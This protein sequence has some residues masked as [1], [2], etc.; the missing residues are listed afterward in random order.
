MSYGEGYCLS[1]MINIPVFNTGG[2]GQR[3]KINIM[4][5]SKKMPLQSGIFSFFSKTQCFSFPGLSKPIVLF[6]R[7]TQHHL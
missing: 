1:K 3:H 7:K 6:S 4:Q 2:K 5:K